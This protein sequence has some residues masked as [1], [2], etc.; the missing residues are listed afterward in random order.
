[1]KDPHIVLGIPRGS[2]WAT[3]KARYRDLA[4][5][6]HPDKLLHLPAEERQRH[7]DMFKEITVAYTY[8]MEGGSRYSGIWNNGGGAGSEEDGGGG[9]KGDEE[10][11]AHWR[12]VWERVEEMFQKKEVWQA[13]GEVL[14]DV[15]TKYKERKAAEAAAARAAAAAEETASDEPHYFDMPVTLEEIFNNKEKKLRLFLKGVSKP[16]IVKVYCGSFPEYRVLYDPCADAS[17]KSW[18]SGKTSPEGDDGNAEDG[19][20]YDIRIRFKVQ[21]HPVFRIDELFGSKDLYA[22]LEITWAEYVSGCERNLTYIN[23]DE[24]V[25]IVPPFDSTGIVIL[26]GYGATGSETESLYVSV[27]TRPP[28]RTEWETAFGAGGAA[29]GAMD[30]LKRAQTQ[31]EQY[32]IGSGAPGA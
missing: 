27:R 24:L 25:V 22:E 23:G 16:I 5:E 26:K 9:G 20:T 13:M 11:N 31:K 18:G 28:S 7:E 19:N 17:W 21:E 32:G 1:M 10:S 8:L 29:E 4:R 30:I 6:H 15:A 3:I 14:K 12:S 2:D